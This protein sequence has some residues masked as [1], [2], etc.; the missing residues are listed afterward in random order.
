M[1]GM[2]T[3]LVNLWGRF[4]TSYWF[5]PSLMVC[6][7]FALAWG[8]STLDQRLAL[9]GWTGLSWIYKGDPAG[10]RTLLSTVAASMITVAGVVFSITIVTLSLTS[11]QFGPRLLRN[12]LRDTTNQVVLG[13][14]VA[15]FLY[16]LLLLRTVRGGP[17]DEFVPHVG[18]SV[19][20]LLALGNVGLLIYFIHH[21]ATSI[22]A[23]SIIGTVS[24][25]LQEAI[26]YLFPQ[27]GES[28]GPAGAAVVRRDTEAGAG[29]AALVPALR[30]G[31]VQ[32]IDVP[33]LVEA[34]AEH[35]V[36]ISLRCRPGHFVMEGA[37]LAEVRP[38]ARSSEELIRRTQR[39]ILVGAHRTAEQDVEFSIHQLV[40]VALRALSPGIND[41]YTAMTCIDWLGAAL[42]RLCDRPFPSPYHEDREGA[43]RL[44][45][46]PIT[47]AGI[48][49]AA[50]NQIRQA[51]RD[52]V[53]VTIRLLEAIAVVAAHAHDA[54]QRAVLVQHAELV[55]Q[56]AKQRTT[57]PRDLQDIAER[58]DGLQRSVQRAPERPAGEA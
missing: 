12:F 20:V 26:D 10:A 13:A 15:T 40:E 27:R 4:R 37:T 41:P 2:K 57:E 34:G 51:A 48:A 6:T 5:V 16:C 17:A 25:E 19:A 30:S 39:G 49:D 9:Q 42:L 29:E 55:Y 21:V 58:F 3:R 38:A 7:A 23:N 8:L 11:S 43:I 56:Q 18:V 53:S 44:I 33:G 52:H 45:T 54:D 31:Y 28:S 22:Q 47:F 32:A 50:F 14:F 46:E 35:D 36:E 24:G 1:A